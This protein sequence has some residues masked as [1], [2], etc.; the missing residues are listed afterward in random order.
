VAGIGLTAV[1]V[2]L[3]ALGSRAPQGSD[4]GHARLRLGWRLAGQRLER[5][6]DLSPQEL[7]ARPV[8]MRQARECVSEPLAYEL[9]ARVDG[10]VVARKLVAPAGLRGDR[11]LSVEEEVDVVP[12]EHAVAVTFTPI[13]AGGSGATLAFER[14]LTFAPARVVLVTHDDGKLVAR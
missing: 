4:P 2:A 5:C 3:L 10:A 13:R 7:A 14:R 12:G 9:T 11:P 8:H 1:A 6:R